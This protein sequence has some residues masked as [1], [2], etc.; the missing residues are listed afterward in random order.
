MAI[1]P[2]SDIVMDVARAAEPADVEAARAALARRTGGTTGS[3]SA[4]QA[5]SIDAGSVL[6]RAAADK[7]EATNPARKFQRFE[8][9]VLQTFIQNMMPKDTEGVYGKGLAGDMWKS[10]LSEQVAD[11]MAK[12]GGI[13]IAR[14]MLADHYLDGKRTVPV[15]PVGGGPLKTE[16]DQQTRLSTSM[17]EELERK[18][19]RSMTGDD[20]TI[21]TDIKI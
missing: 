9:M 1:S 8:A 12:H 16:I 6:S 13:G 3:F 21:K 11:I 19:A 10:Q 5:A 18:A 7:A 14:S 20:A 15:G 2:P 4:D 17:V